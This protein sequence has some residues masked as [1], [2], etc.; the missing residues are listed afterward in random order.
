MANLFMKFTLSFVSLAFVERRTIAVSRENRFGQ[1]GD[2]RIG[3]A[4]DL[5]RTR[6]NAGW[7]SRSMKK[8]VLFLLALTFTAAVASGQAMDNKQMLRR[9]GLT[10][11]QISQFTVIQ[12]EAQ[13]E[14]RASQQDVRAA[15]KQLAQLLLDSKADPKE[16]ERLVH[17]ATDAEAR[18][19]IAQIER[20]MAVRQLIGDRKWQKLQVYLRLR[21]ELL[22]TESGNAGQTGAA[23]AAETADG[24][25]G[26]DGATQQQRNQALLK[27]LL[28]L[29]GGEDE[30]S[31]AR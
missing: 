6:P 8:M 2:K 14:I 25:Q 27:E 31:Q 3:A 28:D 23:A 9:L 12:Q 16:I 30:S 13:P 24:N 5:M 10:D 22:R 26:G 4:W 11:D 17:A 1:T 20:E 18:V 15:Q 29:L 21:R 7:S 19:K